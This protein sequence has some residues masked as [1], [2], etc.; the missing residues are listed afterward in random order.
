MKLFTESPVSAEMLHPRFKY[1]IDKILDSAS[2]DCSMDDI[3]NIRSECE[4]RFG[5][6][7]SRN[8]SFGNPVFVC[9]IEG[10]D[11]VILTVKGDDFKETKLDLAPV[12]KGME[13]LY[14]T[15]Y[16]Q[17]VISEIDPFVD[18]DIC[19]VLCDCMNPI[20]LVNYEDI[21]DETFH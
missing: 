16:I 11:L 8:E 12:P 15:T 1:L 4:F 14:I 7:Q 3:D 19:Q 5:I 17:N 18:Y 6:L 9:F 10:G 13:E 2:E 20:N 21:S